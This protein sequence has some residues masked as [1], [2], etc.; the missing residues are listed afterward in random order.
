MSEKEKNLLYSNNRIDFSD[1]YKN[2]N[3][4]LGKH[5]QKIKHLDVSFGIFSDKRD[6]IVNVFSCE[7]AINFNHECK[8]VSIFN[9]GD[10]F[11]YDSFQIY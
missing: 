5:P 9:A 1:F 4:S 8:Q 2:I 6:K 7:F 10:I 11:Q 3:G